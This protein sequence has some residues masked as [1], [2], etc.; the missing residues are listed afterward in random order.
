MSSTERDYT[1]V[2]SAATWRRLHE[3]LVGEV[4]ERMAFGYCSATSRR[5][6]TRFVLHEVEFP[7]D[8]D[9][10]VQ[11]SARVVLGATNTVRYLMRA[12][13]AAAFLDV[14]SHPFP[15]APHP[16]ATDD[17]AATRQYASLQGPS[18]GAALVRI[19]VSGDG[20]IWAGVHTG[21]E[22][23]EPV[24]RIHILARTG[25]EVVLPVNGRSSALATFQ[26][27]DRRTLAC[28]GE[29]RLSK[30]RGLTV[31]LIHLLKCGQCT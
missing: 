24:D 4:A 17:E 31:G 27:M 20:Q 19:I 30:M 18:P 26:E 14:H 13:G 29:S 7:A 16:S 22:S 15:G 28:L 2:T 8:Q 6:K 9:Y 1:L 25:L 3:H 11:H 21:P 5:G 23:P 10:S 12:K